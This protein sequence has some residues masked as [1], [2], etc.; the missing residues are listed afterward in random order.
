MSRCES[1]S[2]GL[3]R[4][5]AKIAD[6]LEGSDVQGTPNFDSERQ[7]EGRTL[8]TRCEIFLCKERS[9]PLMGVTIY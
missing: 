9:P 6:R 3:E 8:T 7:M 1:E 4:T 2:F 5:M